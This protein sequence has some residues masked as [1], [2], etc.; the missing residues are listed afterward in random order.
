MRQR[1]QRKVYLQKTCE[2]LK[3]DFVWWLSLEYE[4]IQLLDS[5][6]FQVR[7][8]LENLLEREL[9]A[10]ITQPL[11]TVIASI[12]KQTSLDS[13]WQ[14]FLWEK[15][16]AIMFQ[17]HAIFYFE[18]WRKDIEEKIENRI[19]QLREMKPGSDSPRQNLHEHE[20]ILKKLREIHHDW[21]DEERDLASALSEQHDEGEELAE[22]PVPE[23][24]VQ[25]GGIVKWFDYAEGFDYG[26]GFG[27][28]TADDDGGDVFV[29]Q[30]TVERIGLAA[31]E[32][33]WKLRMEVG[34][35]PKGRIA[36]SIKVVSRNVLAATIA[37]VEDRKSVTKLDLETQNFDAAW[38][39][40]NII[41][42]AL[43]EFV[44]K[45]LDPIQEENKWMKYVY[46]KLSIGMQ[47][48]VQTEGDFEALVNQLDVQKCLRV[49]EKNWWKIFKP[50]VGKYDEAYFKEMWGV[51]DTINH[52]SRTT[53]RV[54]WYDAYRMVD[55]MLRVARAMESGEAQR[56]EAIREE[57]SKNRPETK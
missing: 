6:L 2:E 47:G 12:D 56:I 15:Q 44:Q 55:T 40:Y 7:T 30:R 33:G 23:E 11:K 29:H 32:P 57:I 19:E 49:I 18:C 13:I 46:A 34:T 4:F 9:E 16:K 5:Q 3:Q 25:I 36:K 48:D 17:E 10:D 37:K 43:P 50:K 20:Q 1:K 53:K 54:N 42:D 51:R 45:I 41:I 52:A 31:L 28:V 8:F 24:C 35:T 22:T 27:F 38:K 39:A 21:T 26:E 14:M